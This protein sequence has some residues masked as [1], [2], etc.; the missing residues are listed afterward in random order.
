MYKMRVESRTCEEE[1]TG[2]G[3]GESRARALDPETWG[4]S[5]LW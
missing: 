2:E 3:V 5:Q 4:L 1:N